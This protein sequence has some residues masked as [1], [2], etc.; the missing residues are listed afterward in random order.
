M[1][2]RCTTWLSML[3]LTESEGLSAL[4][5]ARVVCPVSP[6]QCMHDPRGEFT[7]THTVSP[8]DI[9]KPCT[10]MTQLTRYAV[11]TNKLQKCVGRESETQ[12]SYGVLRRSHATDSDTCTFVPSSVDLLCSPT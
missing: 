12:S 8:G 2:R 9:K 7:C 4:Y 6:V 10:R 11:C 3:K 1:R 5:C